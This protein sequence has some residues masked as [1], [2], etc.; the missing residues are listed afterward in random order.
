MI[1]WECAIDGCA[2]GFDSAEALIAHQETEHAGHECRV[3][4]RSVADGYRAIS[5][6]FEEHTRTEYVRAYEANAE[7]IR[8]RETVLRTVES[9]LDEPVSVGNETE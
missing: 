1:G 3:C 5:H 7:A 4:G 6:T 9:A 2:V 8:V